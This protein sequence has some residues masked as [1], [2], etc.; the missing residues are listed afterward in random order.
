VRFEDGKAL[1]AWPERGVAWEDVSADAAKS[2]DAIGSWTGTDE[3]VVVRWHEGSETVLARDGEVLVEDPAGRWIALPDSEGARPEGTWERR[4]P[5]GDARITLRKDGTFQ[6]RGALSLLTNVT[7]EKLPGAGKGT[8]EIRACTLLLSCED[9]TTKSIAYEVIEGT[10]E[11]P[12]KIALNTCG[13]ELKK[14]DPLEIRYNPRMALLPPT[15]PSLN[16]PETRPYFLWWTDSTFDDLRR[17]LRSA[18]ADARANWLGALLREANTR[19]VWLFT[20]PGEI[21]EAWPRLVAFLGRSRAMWAWL[22][23][24][25]DPGWPPKSARG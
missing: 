8:Y 6:E 15:S 21:R 16:L 4:N 10:A 22:L 7:Q 18:D 24:L 5:T 11:K 20:D 9:G 3:G 2:D 25:E 1:R 13:L 14:W 23:G 12:E 19:D 17:H